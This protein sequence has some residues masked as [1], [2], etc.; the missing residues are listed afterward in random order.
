[1]VTANIQNASGTSTGYLITSDTAGTGFI[2]GNRFSALP[3]TPLLV[4][5]SRGYVYGINYH[6]DTAD[7]S[8]YIIPAQDS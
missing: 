2:D 1:M 5:A 6:T 8:G 7:T 3:T 4:T